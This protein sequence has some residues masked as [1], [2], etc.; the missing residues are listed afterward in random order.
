MNDRSYQ[1]GDLTTLCG[2][3]RARPDDTGA[4]DVIFVILLLCR[5]RLGPGNETSHWPWPGSEGARR[6]RQPP[7][8]SMSFP[9][10]RCVYKLN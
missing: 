5:A 1:S 8:I 6:G 3:M 7:N 10:R 4:S 9:F 2:P